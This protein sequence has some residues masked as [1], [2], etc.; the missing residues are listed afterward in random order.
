MINL[1]RTAVENNIAWCHAVCASH[2]YR[3]HVSEAVWVNLLASPPFYPNI[4]TRR[5][6]AQEEVGDLVS[7]L[8]QSGLP[9]GWG[10]KDSFSDLDL[11]GLGFDAAIAGQWWGSLAAPPRSAV[12][13]E[14]EAI[15]TA[16]D[17]DR[18]QRAWAGGQPMSIFNTTLLDDERLT[19]WGLPRDGEI[20]AGF[21]TFLS[22]GGI[23][24]SNWFSELDATPFELG[25]VA[26]AHECSGQLPVI[27]WD[28]EAGD[29]PASA[30]LLVLGSMRVW[31]HRPTRP[32]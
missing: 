7:V 28:D 4:V 31:L 2:R 8:L 30:G 13:Q 6:N 11:S 25:M 14:W 16:R 29:T 21:V 23:G 24:L 3:G 17:L 12:E 19:F 10:I 27:W 15:G 20:A 26:R 1:L 18:W 9:D 22:E 32:N 5:P